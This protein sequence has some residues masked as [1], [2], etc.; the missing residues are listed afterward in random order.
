MAL[1]VIKILVMKINDPVSTLQVWKCLSI[2]VCNNDPPPLGNG[3]NLPQDILKYCATHPIYVT[4]QKLPPIWII[5]I[6]HKAWHHEQYR[7]N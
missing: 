1:K 5:G 3:E 7:K 4:G 6:I 2:V